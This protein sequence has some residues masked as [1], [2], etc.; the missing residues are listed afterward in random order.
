MLCYDDLSI[1]APAFAGVVLGGGARD[2]ILPLRRL[3]RH[4]PLAG[5]DRDGI[6]LGNRARTPPLPHSRKTMLHL[7]TARAC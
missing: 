4:L 1:W 6:G 3:W 2:P 5:E 7:L